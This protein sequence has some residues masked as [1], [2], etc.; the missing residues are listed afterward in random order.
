[1][2]EE[3][4]FKTLIQERFT[5][6]PKAVQNAILSGNPEKR[7]R[8]LSKEHRLHLDQWQALENLVMLTLFGV[9]HAEELQKRITDDIGVPA[10]SALALT[11]DITTMI[12]EPIREG[13]ERELEHPQAK[14]EERSG[15]ERARESILRAED[16][17]GKIAAKPAP[18]PVAPIVPATPPKV[19][20][21]AKAERAPVS[22]SYKPHELSSA[23]KDTEGDPYR[24]PPL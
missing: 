23:R 10:D 15:V 16:R 22:P 19:P 4:D 24:E 3:K 18:S 7:L 13:L 2:T 11:N 6:L 21:T 9:Y 5:K 12:F 17:N 8:E 14:E 1:M 20:S